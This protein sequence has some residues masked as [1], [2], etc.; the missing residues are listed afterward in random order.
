MLG[1]S[2]ESR[3]DGRGRG[4]GN[5]AATQEVLDEGTIVDPGALQVEAALVAAAVTNMWEEEVDV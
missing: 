2:A 5:E 4:L 1:R 3:G